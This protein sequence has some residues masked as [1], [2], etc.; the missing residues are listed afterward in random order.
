MEREVS[1][2]AHES[3]NGEPLADLRRHPQFD[4]LRRRFQENSDVPVAHNVSE[5][6]P[7][8]AVQ[9]RLVFDEEL[10]RLAEGIRSIYGQFFVGKTAPDVIGMLRDVLLQYLFTIEDM[11]PPP[12][13]DA[14]FDPVLRNLGSQHAGPIIQ[15][16][17][18]AGL[19]LSEDNAEVVA[20]VIDEFLG[21]ASEKLR[22]FSDTLSAQS[23]TDAALGVYVEPDEH[24]HEKI[25]IVWEDD[26][27][28]KHSVG[29]LRAEC[30]ELCQE[31]KYL[32]NQEL[33]GDHWMDRRLTMMF[34][35]VSRHYFFGGQK[36]GGYQE[37]VT[38]EVLEAL[39][40]HF[41]ES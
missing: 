5:E 36:A 14:R 8:T 13:P 29:M 4:D 22:K 16:L 12:A 9:R 38:F 35:L 20:E 31:Y 7:A 26:L 41:F 17:V 10:E 27:G 30:D 32:A 11:T 40:R 6:H 2:K 24:E 28:Q 37:S 3:I 21:V 34:V 23:L 18:V 15:R 39:K 33:R 1:R 25:K 19:G